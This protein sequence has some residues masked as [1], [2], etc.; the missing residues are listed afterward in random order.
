MRLT[1]DN[2]QEF[3][4]TLNSAIKKHGLSYSGKEAFLFDSGDCLKVRIDAK[5]PYYSYCYKEGYVR[6]PLDL[7][8]HILVN[9]PSMNEVEDKLMIPFYN[10]T[11]TPLTI[12]GAE[13]E[14]GFSFYLE[15]S[16]WAV[17]LRVGYGAATLI[18]TTLAE[19]EEE[20]HE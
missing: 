10:R 9:V 6:F 17:D 15:I 4:E 16:Q 18:K 20:E 1:K 12:I 3:I 5:N 11:K 19:I 7:F 8:P 2:L 13:E 14:A